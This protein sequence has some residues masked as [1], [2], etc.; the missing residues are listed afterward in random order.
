MG[1]TAAFLAKAAARLALAIL[2]AKRLRAAE[3]ADRSRKDPVND[4]HQLQARG[5]QARKTKARKV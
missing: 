2:E 4:R 5:E 1:P 3:T